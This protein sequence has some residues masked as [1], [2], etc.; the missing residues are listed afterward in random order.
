[1]LLSGLNGLKN[2]VSHDWVNACGS[3]IKKAVY[4]HA[5][6][7]VQL[8]QCN[9]LLQFILN[10]FGV[11]VLNIEVNQDVK[12]LIRVP[13]VKN[14]RVRNTCDTKEYFIGAKALE[15]LVSHTK[16]LSGM[17]KELVHKELLTNLANA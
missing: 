8:I 9:E 13:F 2:C 3:N 5:T 7:S 4:I 10:R 6:I 16:N 11:S 15:A 14:L 17:A 1:M 12:V